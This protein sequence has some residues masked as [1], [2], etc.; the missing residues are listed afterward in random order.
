VGWAAVASAVSLTLLI[1]SLAAAPDSAPKYMGWNLL[2]AWLPVALGCLL[3]W[4]ARC[5]VARV[6]VAGAGVVWLAFL[7]NAPYLV[8]DLVHAGTP[9]GGST[10][11]DII[12]LITF[13][14]T[15]LVMFFAA[16][17]AASEAARLAA[18]ERWARA[19]APVCA[20]VASIGMYLGR[21]LRWNS[22]D[23]V[24][25]PLGR[26]EA[27]VPFVRTPADILKAASFVLAISVIL[28]ASRAVLERVLLRPRS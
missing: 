22:W 25:R 20:L 3:F 19:V 9:Y 6:G 8:T 15:G 27:A 17:T 5:R 23:L 14:I 4:C 1:I 7:P 2:L 11:L 18:G 12:T 28:I 10:R 16:V 24:V 13:A 21:V 26:V